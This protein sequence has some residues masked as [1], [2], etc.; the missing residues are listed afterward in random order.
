MA[1]PSL[2]A[3]NK[4]SWG[5]RMFRNIAAR[6]DPETYSRAS[7]GLT[8]DRF[9]IAKGV[10]GKFAEI[11]GGGNQ[12]VIERPSG[13]QVDA[14][15]ALL[16]FRG[17]PYAAINAIAREVMNIEFRLFST[18]GDDPTQ[19]TTHA[20]LDLLDSVNDAMTGP[21][22]KYI[23]SAHLSLAGNAYWYLDGVK[24]DLGK[25]TAIYPIDP[26]KMR[27]LIDKTT[28]PYLPRR[29]SQVKA[30]RFEEFLD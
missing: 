28:W 8:F 30:L 22:L 9:G 27:I 5:V 1:S 4:P 16:N 13:G 7:G 20:A 3:N 29:N 24:D 17:F 23:L 21:E 6:I 19:I 14:A 2:N 12:F 18:K 10:G 25:P 26:S 15:R 11:N